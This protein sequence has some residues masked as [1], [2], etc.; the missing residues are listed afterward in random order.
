MNKRFWQWPLTAV[1]VATLV[2]TVIPSPAG[3]QDPNVY[4]SIIMTDILS[5]APVVN[6]VFTTDME[7]SITNNASPPAVGVQGVELWLAFDPAVV[8]VDDY[9]DNPS[10]GIQ[11]EPR[12][13]FFDGQLVV[14]ANEVV[15]GPTMPPNAP[16]ACVTAGACVH[17][18]LSHTGGSGAIT[19]R[20]GPIATIT[21]AALATGS[22]DFEVVVISPG[23]P[24]GSVLSDSDGLPIPINSTYVPDIAVLDSGTVT[25]HVYRQGVSSDY[26]GATVTAVSVD[27]GVI[28]TT[29]TNADGS[30]ALPVPIGDTYTINASY[31]GYLQSQEIS[32][33]VVGVSV[34]IGSTSLVGG[35][36]NCDNC[37]N[38][39]D[40]V[41]IIGR[42]GEMGLPDSDP[43]D[44][45]DDGS[46][47]V[48][49]LT[50]ASGNFTRC[51]PT[52]WGQ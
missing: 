52:P 13:G 16:S 29:S 36:V 26:S 8:A 14:G 33:Y 17:L 19:N 34:N 45:N 21:W 7:V 11:V 30:F 38:I 10:N 31:P 22:P 24:P 28:A 27:K 35:D 20:S 48:L 44:I 39:L 41:S 49:D 1:V 18:A 23:I 50:I 15:F 40:V 9:D 43:A 46:I 4:T 2:L 6:G 47:N 37:I 51:G 12:S 3:A 25:G 32:V 5:G 42:F